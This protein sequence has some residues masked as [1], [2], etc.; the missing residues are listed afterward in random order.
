MAGKTCETGP[1]QTKQ[2]NKI[3]Y[4]PCKTKITRLLR[5]WNTEVPK[6]KKLVQLVSLRSRNKLL[7]SAKLF[8]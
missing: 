8:M 2:K 7:E 1:H 5:E 4:R 6:A 3:P